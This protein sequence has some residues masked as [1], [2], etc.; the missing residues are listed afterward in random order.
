M[1]GK[2]DPTNHFF[3]PRILAVL[4]RGYGRGDLGS[5]LVAGFTVGMIALPL[6]LALGIASVPAGTQTPLSAPAMGVI[7]AIIAGLLISLLGGSRFQIGGPAAA[8]VPVVLL[9]IEQ[10]GFGGLMLATVMAGIILVIMGLAR[11]GAV[12]KFVPWP[13]TGGITTGI[14]VSI[15][16]TQAGDL[17]GIHAGPPPRAFPERVQWLWENLPHANPVNL[18]ISAG[19]VAII[20]FWPRL[21]IKNIPGPVVAV[22]AATLVVLVAGLQQGFD[23]ATIGEKYGADAIPPSLPSLHWPGFTWSQVRDL[24]GSATAI[25][26][27][28]ATGSLLS[29]T[30]ADGMTDDSHDSNTELIAQGVANIVCPFFCGLP[31]AGALVR[32][33][34]N[35]ANGARSPVSGIVHSGTLLLVILLFSKGAAFVPVAALSAVLVAVAFRM[36]EWHEMTRLARMPRSDAAVF[37]ATFALTVI[38]DLVIAVEV[39]MVLAAILFVKRVSQSTEVSRGTEDGVPETPEQTARG[40]IIPKGVFAYRVSSPFLF[41]AA[42]KMEDA[43]KGVNKMPEVLILRLHLVGEMD[44][45]ALNTLES[46]TERMRKH[47]GAVILSGLHRQPLDMLLS[48]GFAEVIGRKNLCAHFDAA[49]ARAREILRG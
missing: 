31:A 32:T 28:G 42:E 33:S 10:H 14:A 29:A 35:V 48:S 25:A 17:L 38:F 8:F 7:T 15:L 22:L 49:L 6:V 18:A 39:G 16:A 24:I 13:V 27:L 44:A 1:N 5:D 4:S 20:F 46:I 21:G 43:L 47:G 40:K 30:V 3:A 12:I 23:V 45:T 41:G 11:L 36:G 26:L 9:V 34:A 19:C 2:P 37:L